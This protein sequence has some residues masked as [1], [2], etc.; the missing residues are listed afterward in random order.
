LSSKV[1]GID[2]KK[3]PFFSILLGELKRML[4]AHYPAARFAVQQ[5][6]DDPGI[7]HLV[8][9]VDVEDTDTVL[10]VGIDRVLESQVEEDLVIH[11]P[12]PKIV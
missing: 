4:T 1:N 11:E 9:T 6:I 7:I 10:D 2:S 8:T 12:V 3:Q 5:G